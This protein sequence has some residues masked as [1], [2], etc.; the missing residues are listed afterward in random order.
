[1]SLK[2]ILFGKLA[3]ITGNSLTVNNVADTDSLI[4]ELHKN[5]PC[6]GWYEIYNCSR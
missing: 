5:Y 2:I 4:N 6:I 1:M 3:D